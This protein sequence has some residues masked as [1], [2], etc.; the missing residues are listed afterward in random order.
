M[1]VKKRDIARY[2]ITIRVTKD[3][4]S[5]TRSCDDERDKEKLMDDLLRCLSNGS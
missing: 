4:S 1:K 2:R 3:G 5:I